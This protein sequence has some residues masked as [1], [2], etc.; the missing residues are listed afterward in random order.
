MCTLST[1]MH[2]LRSTFTEYVKLLKH[3]KICLMES[4]QILNFKYI[5]IYIYNLFKFETKFVS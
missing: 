3:E 5:Y 1:T 4:M 2:I